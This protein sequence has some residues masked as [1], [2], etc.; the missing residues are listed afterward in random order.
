MTKYVK[1]QAQEGTMTAAKQQA[2]GVSVPL[3]LVSER[4][5]QLYR[6][7]RICPAVTESFAL[8]KAVRVATRLPTPAAAVPPKLPV[9]PTSEVH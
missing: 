2:P 3:L 4:G 1:A 9:S 5:S 7:V 6:H 8:Y